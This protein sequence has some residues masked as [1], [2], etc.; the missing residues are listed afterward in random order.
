MNHVALVLPTVDRVA[1]AERQVL[2]LAKGLLRRGWRV[3]V[4]ALSGSGGD[5]ACELAAAGAAFLSLEMRK[6]LADPRGW[7]RFRR[8]IRHESPDIIHA[9]LPH[10]A[11]MARWMRLFAPT[12]VVIDSVHTSATGTLGRRLG[13]RCSNWLPDRVSAVSQGAADAYCTARMAS[14]RRL[15]L[16]SNGVDTRHWRPEP[17]VRVQH[18]KR[19]GLTGRFLW[20]AAGRLDPVKGY[21]TLLRAMME[22]P[23]E[24]LL[25]V[26]GAG[27]D[28][29]KLRSMAVEHGLETRVQF[30]GFQPDVLPWMQAA[31]AFVLSS[32]WE[33]LPMSLLE[34]GACAL[35]AVVTD[36]PG[37]REIIEHGRNGFLAPSGDISSLGDAM[38]RMMRLSTEERASMG[39]DAR[40]RVVAQFSLDAVLD[41]WED[42]YRELLESHPRPARWAT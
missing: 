16:L 4:V 3:T 7:T 34:A 1:G 30:L 9:H 39:T 13:Y 23:A 8:W 25:V 5:S 19:F 32:R 15:V 31:D 42:L 2:L 38:T 41:R 11:W 17:S 40:R 28:E 36:V 22:V 10:A 18:H 29:G 26:A 14:R 27:P 37:S 20:F 6:G 12:R 21:P 33:G 24:A 35:P